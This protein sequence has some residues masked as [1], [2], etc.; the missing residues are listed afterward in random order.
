MSIKT[1]FSPDCAFE[2]DENIQDDMYEK[3]KEILLILKDFVDSTR[4]HFI[5]VKSL[6]DS[7][8]KNKC[9]KL[10]EITTLLKDIKKLPAMTSIGTQTSGSKSEQEN[11]MVAPSEI[12]KSS[13]NIEHIISEHNTLVEEA[14]PPAKSHMSKVEDL[15]NVPKT[16]ASTTTEMVFDLVKTDNYDKFRSLVDNAECFPNV[17][18]L[19]HLSF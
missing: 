6:I 5:S 9:S 11:E 17:P 3:T 7:S 1:E 19:Y 10:D 14:P 16:R 8:S 13:F 2:E 4:S 12:A 18:K 15:L